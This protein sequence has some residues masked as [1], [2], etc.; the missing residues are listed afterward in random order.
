MSIMNRDAEGQEMVGY[1]EYASATKSLCSVEFLRVHSIYRFK[2][3][4]VL[5][6][7]LSLTQ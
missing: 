5:G 6:K 2:N 1:N 4:A 3:V 7:S